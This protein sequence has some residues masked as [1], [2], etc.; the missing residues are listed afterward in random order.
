VFALDPLSYRPFRLLAIGRVVDMLGTAIGPV[1][2]A[3]AVLD[4]T[5]SSTALGLVVASF[6]LANVVFLLLGGVVADRLPRNLVLLGSCAGAAAVETALT[7]VVA[8]R[9]DSVP[10]LA[11]LAALGGALAAFAFPAS[12]ALLPSTVPEQIRQQATALARLGTN[13]ALVVGSS[14]A[15]V[16]VGLA[17]PAWGLGIDAGSYVV[18]G[19]LYAAVHVPRVQG[20]GVS[21]GA[22]RAAGP[23]AEPIWR[24]LV[25]GWRIFSSRRWLWVVVAAFGIINACWGGAL[26]VL[27]PVIADETFGRIWWGAISGALTLGLVFGG[28][29]ALRLRRRR[30]LGFGMA[31]M[32]GQVLLLICLGAAPLVPVLLAGALVAG[33]AL[34][35]FGVAWDLSMQQHVPA[36]SLARAYS[37]DMLGS[38]VATP[39]GEVLAGPLATHFG[40]RATVLGA[41]VLAGAAIVAALAVRAVRDLPNTALAAV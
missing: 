22:A 26:G 40:A 12:S 23:A 16:I 11:A 5:H 20:P 19:G 9:I 33:V 18:A 35:Q 27:G 14:L 2:L 3:F 41:A 1:A 17:G 31:C 8:A 30:L 39:L 10:L 25:H 29:I 36:D 34:E 37:Y 38:L 24:E 6:S 32:F 21:D 7:A 13:G 28:L 15:G 4:L